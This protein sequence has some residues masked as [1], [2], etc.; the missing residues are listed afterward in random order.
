MPR[1]RIPILLWISLSC[2]LLAVCGCRRSGAAAWTTNGKAPFLIKEEIG[3]IFP[4]P[5][6]EDVEYSFCINNPSTSED[7]HLAV[8]AK[9][10]TCLEHSL[11]PSVV[12]PG[13]S[14][15]VTLR[16]HLGSGVELH[17]ST[18]RL[19]S[20]RPECPSVLLCG[21][22]HV[23]SR[24]ATFVPKECVMRPGSRRCVPFD[25]VACAPLHESIS[26]TMLLQSEAE[27]LIVEVAAT[28]AE[29]DVVKGVG[30]R[31]FHCM[32]CITCPDVEPDE[33]GAM[34]F[35]Y[36]FQVRHAEYQLK[37]ELVVARRP[38]V[39]AEPQEVFFG[40]AHAGLERRVSIVAKDG[41]F[42]IT[43]VFSPSA[44]LSVRLAEN[45]EG[46][47]LYIGLK[48]L[49]E[50]EPENPSNVTRTHVDVEIEHPTQTTVRVPVFIVWGA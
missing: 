47:W 25:V 34:R 40:N 14:A 39:V 13:K 42:S 46:Q 12:S 33:V 35:A 44:L 38:Y 6:G 5:D 8:E 3:P 21:D 20:D 32:A 7:M 37:K 41:Q 31:I 26:D 9:S 49:K 2:C 48:E 10:C 17:R 1:A 29:D 45:S 18:V 23:F 19:A 16:A 30:R 15:T 43:R 24:L 4:G 27:N 11:E 50:S 28:E 22:A 36:P